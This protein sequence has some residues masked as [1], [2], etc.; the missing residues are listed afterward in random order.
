MTTMPIAAAPMVPQARQAVLDE[1]AEFIRR[2]MRVTV[3]DAIEVG[4]RLTEAKEWCGHGNWLTWLGREFEWDERTARR[5]I[6]VYELSLKSDTLA[7]LSLK[8]PLSAAYALSA[9]STP[10]EV[11]RA[12]IAAAEGGEKLTVAKVRDAIAEAR[13]DDPPSRPRRRPPEEILT[14]DMSAQLVALTRELLDEIV[15][16]MRKMPPPERA[17]FQQEVMERLSGE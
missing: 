4:R 3:R 5:F 8:I 17:R 12:V 14:P 2:F 6:D 1:H 16:L 9:P 10:V 13:D 15:R 7:D 11:Q